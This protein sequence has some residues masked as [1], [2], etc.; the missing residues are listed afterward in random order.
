MSY[1]DPKTIIQSTGKYYTQLSQSLAQTAG[2]YSETVAREAERRRR[3]AMRRSKISRDY[4]TQ[5]GSLVNQEV[6]KGETT[7]GNVDY[8]T[9]NNLV[10][11]GA[12]IKS[13]DISSPEQNRLLQGVEG[14][15]GEIRTTLGAVNTLVEGADQIIENTGLAGGLD[16]Y[17]PQNT[18]TGYAMIAGAIP[19]KSMLTGRLN[20]D[21]SPEVIMQFTG[22]EGTYTLTGT[23]LKGLIDNPEGQLGIVNPDLTE[24]RK[25]L[26][27]NNILAQA[28]DGSPSNKYRSSLMSEKQRSDYNKATGQTEFFKDPDVDK[29]KAVLY[30][31]A[32]ATMMSLSNTEQISEFNRLGGDLKLKEFH[33]DYSKALSKD[34]VE[35]LTKRYISNV[36]EEKMGPEPSDHSISTGKIAPVKPSAADRK[37][38]FD[39]REVNDRGVYVVNKLQGAIAGNDVASIFVGEVVGSKKDRVI[40][41]SV[42][43]DKQYVTL[44][45]DG[46]VDDRVYDLKKENDLSKLVDDFAL[47]EYPK[48]GDQIKD[49]YR[50]STKAVEQ[51]KQ[52]GASR[53]NEQ[54][55]KTVQEVVDP[56]AKENK[57]PFKQRQTFR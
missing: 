18:Q 41:A 43:D 36:I 9:F 33:M 40:N 22:K 54:N 11:Q 26:W 27:N 29:I 39:A 10:T 4:Q 7:F 20:E 51:E 19:N 37:R 2:R 53:F 23:E 49:W 47:I 5:K 44:Q 57:K 13:L 28:A 25:N 14:M 24:Q 42:S 32:R 17:A 15:P 38:A 48:S 35:E 56:N 30:E 1:R 55:K 16:A 12:E 8:A 52:K 50:R 46:D 6:R 34:E 3:E 21:G 45:L 31:D